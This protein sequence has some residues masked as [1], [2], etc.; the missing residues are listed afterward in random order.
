MRQVF[1][2]EL[3]D[4]PGG[5]GGGRRGG[6]WHF[7]NERAAKG[8]RNKLLREVFDL[9]ADV[10]EETMYEHDANISIIPISA[11][12]RSSEPIELHDTWPFEEL[13]A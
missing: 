1:Q 9:P 12:S 2:V 11:Y 7:T 8:W 5:R 4:A 6:Q 3:V 10:D 13:R